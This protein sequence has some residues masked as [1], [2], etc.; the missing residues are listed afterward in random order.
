MK[1]IHVIIAVLL[2][3]TYALNGQSLE[4]EKPYDPQLP[5]VL[6]P[7]PHAM[8]Y[9]RYGQIPVSY[10][11]GVPEITIPIYTLKA[12]GLEIPINISYHASGVKV[13]DIAG[14]V[15][16]GWT[17]NA[18]GIIAQ[19]VY[20][21]ADTKD[22][23]P[24]DLRN[25][26]FSSAEQA[27]QL[28][29][30]DYDNYAVDDPFLGRIGH[31]ERKWYGY[32]SGYLTANGPA[33]YYPVSYNTIS[34]RFSYNFNGNLGAFRYNMAEQKYE[35]LPYSAL[36]ITTGKNGSKDSFI[37][38]DENGIN[39]T[40]TH[41]SESTILEAVNYPVTA[42]EY[43]LTSVRFPGIS[44][45]LA[46]TYDNG[47]EYDVRN[48]TESVFNGHEVSFQVDITNY[49]PYVT[50]TTYSPQTDKRDLSYLTVRSKPAHVKTITWKDISVSFTYASDRSG[51]IKERLDNISVKSGSSE[52]NTA[53]AQINKADRM[54]LD[55]ITVNGET[56]AFKY[57]SASAIP[58]VNP[59][60][61]NYYF[62]E[63]FWGYY[64]AANSHWKLIP[65]EWEIIQNSPIKWQ[66]NYKTIR[67]ANP[68][69]TQA[70][71]LYEIHYPA[72]GKTV[73][74]YEQNRGSGV[75]LNV[76]A[77][78]PALDYFGGLRIRRII[79][80]DNNGEI[81]DWK[82]YEYLAGGP[83]V[84]L[85]P[86]HFCYKKDFYYIPV[87]AMDGIV[88]AVAGAVTVLN[89]AGVNGNAYPFTEYGGQAA[90]YT[91]VIEYY[92]HTSINEGK[93]EYIFDRDSLYG[94]FCYMMEN[95]LYASSLNNCDKGVIKPLL[96]SK[97]DYEY[98]GGTYVLLKETSNTY[99]KV[100]K[101]SFIAGVDV[102]HEYEFQPKLNYI[103][104]VSQTQ[105]LFDIYYKNFKFYN[106]YAIRDFMLLDQTTTKMSKENI[107]ITNNYAYDPSYRL[108]SP[109]ETSKTSS[110]SGVTEVEKITHPFNYTAA[111]YTEMTNANII[112][113]VIAKKKY[114]NGTTL[115]ASIQN[116]YVKSNNIFVIDNISASTGNNPL[117]KRIQFHKYDAY[118]NPVYISKDDAAHIVYLW[119]NKGEQLI[120]ELKNASYAQ[121]KTA[122]NNVDPE[123]LSSGIPDMTVINNLRQ[124]TTSLKDAHVTTFTYKPLWGISS[125]TDPAGLKTYYEYDA[126]GRLAKIKDN[127][128][129]L[130][131]DYA[132]KFSSLTTPSTS[133]MPSLSISPA[134]SQY[135]LNSS[136]SFSAGV[137]GGSG[138]Y[139]YNWIF[140]KTDGT[141]LA[142]SLN[143]SSASFTLMFTQTGPMILVCGVKD[144]TTGEIREA[145]KELEVIPPKYSIKF[146]NIQTQ[147]SLMG[148]PTETTAKINCLYETTISISVVLTTGDPLT[149]GL[150]QIASRQIALSYD[151]PSA[152]TTITLPP[153]E[154]NVKVRLE[155]YSLRSSGVTLSITGVSDSHSQL[156][157]PSSI[158]ASSQGL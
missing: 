125:E 70:G 97:K 1:T 132:Y 31:I 93:T 66:R 89:E 107:S 80:Y 39:W 23:G 131:N 16:L 52:M 118:A 138:S 76:K 133:G 116:N 2:L 27:A 50:N 126:Y 154:T 75:Y 103:A 79:N 29:N 112:A 38:T 59:E 92:G 69:A 51:L 32:L 60:D 113:P 56:Y 142:Q 68:A 136:Q 140:K 53:F 54:L 146:T 94:D 111:P 158:S 96:V 58:P 117:E 98:T 148:Q 49:F 37:I 141:I 9:M 48:Y 104:L 46:L 134:S 30:Q 114:K 88:G 35:T 95:P 71:S 115:L 25:I 65:Y 127:E 34:D 6:F 130:I 147:Q 156:A 61:N 7:S 47:A 14:S 86:E 123:S 109:V 15:G 22:N 20:S 55:K 152:Q 110:V 153:G 91:K 62:S 73:F 119:G 105:G 124:N 41:L 84:T 72:K 149:T 5:E 26:P 74:E 3:Q 13:K 122:L 17:L 135:N 12:N 106:I 67:E 18:G 139:A 10:S 145:V 90:F 128:S 45:T 81:A 155:T 100:R 44:D 77:N 63:D 42:K 57:K 8:A 40:F 11:T 19:T 4:E 129:K 121:V 87:H 83:G 99:R 64:N 36:K 108:L 102:K 143:S 157:P 137:P 21:W 120:A 24:H 28:L 43:Y 151:A 33:P 101:G 150:C 78:E 85:T 144:L 82:T